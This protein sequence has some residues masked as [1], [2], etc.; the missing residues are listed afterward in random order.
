MSI[1]LFSLNVKNYRRSIDLLEVLREKMKRLKKVYQ[2]I[3]TPSTEV[4]RGVVFLHNWFIRHR[5]WL[6]DMS[7]S[8]LLIF[9]FVSYYTLF[10]DRKDLVNYKSLFYTWG[11]KGLCSV[12]KDRI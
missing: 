8:V 6:P 1:Y 10:L 4:V 11:E 5:P 3:R 9:V 7:V 2:L 12:D